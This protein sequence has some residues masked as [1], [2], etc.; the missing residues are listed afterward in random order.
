MQNPSRNALTAQLS[1][2]PDDIP[3]RTAL[4]RDL[5]DT[6]EASLDGLR[7]AAGLG[8]PAAISAV[9]QLNATPHINR[10]GPLLAQLR[11]LPVDHLE[12]EDAEPQWC[13]ALA[14]LPLRTLALHYPRFSCSQEIWDRLPTAVLEALEINGYWRNDGDTSLPSLERLRRLKLETRS[15]DFDDDFFRQLGSGRLEALWLN[16]C[17]EVTDEGLRA[18]APLKLRSLTLHDAGELT[19]RGMAQL[20]GHPLEQ[21]SISNGRRILDE[22][23]WLRDLGKLRSLSLNDCSATDAMLPFI[24]DLPIERLALGSS[25]VCEEGLEAL[26]GMPLAELDLK[27]SR[28]VIE[29]LDVLHA[30]PLKRL[31]LADIQGIDAQTLGDLRGLALESLDLSLNELGWKELKQLAGLPLKRLSLSFCQGVDGKVL[32]KLVDLGLPLEQ[33]EISG[34]DLRDDDL[35]CLRHLPLQRL[36]LYESP[37]LT[38][39]GVAH[40]AH[41]PLRDLTLE[42]GP[43][44]SQLTSAMVSVLEQLPLQRLSLRNGAGISAQGWDRLARLPARVVGPGI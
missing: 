23:S 4:Y 2:T 9:G 29:R 43:G 31:V 38:D 42:A 18:L 21:L 37:W 25:Y 39:A 27:A 7:V 12:L 14:G 35:A 40:L 22:P 3:T 19:S 41:L 6:G 30:F 1:T 36:G 33:L 13:D 34:L 26:E 5:L 24:R 11:G 10:P 20:C 17:D 28:M 32:R 8:D 15:Q 44:E 16:N